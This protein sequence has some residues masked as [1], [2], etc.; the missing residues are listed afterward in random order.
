MRRKKPCREYI[1]FITLSQY[2]YCIYKVR[3]NNDK[4]RDSV[5][6]IGKIYFTDSTELRVFE[7]VQ[8]K[9]NCRNSENSA[10][11]AHSEVSADKRVM[12]VVIVQIEQT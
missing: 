5:N 7:T 2:R 10:E 1:S 4:C 11:N 6:N 3:N 12:I 8:K 9:N